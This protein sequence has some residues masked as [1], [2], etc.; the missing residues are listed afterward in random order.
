MNGASPPQ[1][2][3]GQ[4]KW[5]M[6]VRCPEIIAPACFLGLKHQ[7]MSNRS[8]IDSLDADNELFIAR[9]AL[10]KWSRPSEILCIYNGDLQFLC[11]FYSEMGPG[12]LIT[13]HRFVHKIHRDHNYPGSRAAQT[14]GILV[15]N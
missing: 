1:K 9:T 12:S 10:K 3:I 15:T 4:E 2:K 7:K 14:E 6:G 8:K 13:H 11:F 5:L